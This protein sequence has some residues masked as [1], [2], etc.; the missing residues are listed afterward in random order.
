M[1]RQ[2]QEFQFRLND[3]EKL[4][5]YAQSAA[6]HH[7]T[8]IASL[9]KAEASSECWEN[10]ARDGAASVIRA[11]KERDEAKQEARAAQLVATEAGN[12][13]AKVEVDL[14]KALNSLAAAKESGCRSEAEITCL[15]AEFSRVEVERE[16]LLLELEESK[17]KVS[18]L[19][20]RANK[21]REDMAEDYQGSLDLIFAYG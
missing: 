8:L 21:D 16:S 20:A 3:I 15:K 10:E 11:E 18:S 19:H 5:L 1:A 12:P 13:K 14:T 7:Q 4:Q 2:H 9:A 6:S 17:P